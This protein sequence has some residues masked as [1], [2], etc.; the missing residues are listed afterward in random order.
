MFA[1]QISEMIEEE[2]QRRLAAYIKT[3]ADHFFTTEADLYKVIHSKP[4][5]C[6][7]KGKS[8]NGKSCKN[9]GKHDGYCHLHKSQRPKKKVPRDE[10]REV[11]R[12][13][14]VGCAPGIVDDIF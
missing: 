1:E 14:Q 5:V 4:E 6:Y 13:E 11:I 8:R 9:K 3:F 10:P 2:V 7:C 12:H